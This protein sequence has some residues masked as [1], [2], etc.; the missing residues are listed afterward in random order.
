MTCGTSTKTPNITRRAR[1]A[2]KRRCAAS[3][4]CPSASNA[5]PICDPMGALADAA[6][7]NRGFDLPRAIELPCVALCVAQLTFFAFSYLHGNW[8]VQPDGTL[9][10]NDFVN[11]WAAGQ[12]VL[13]GHAAEAYDPK[14]HKLVEDAAVG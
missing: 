13:H 4:S 3:G 11:V 9:V 5:P 12:Q 10:A 6:L 1:Q 8:L 2:S 7:R 14:L